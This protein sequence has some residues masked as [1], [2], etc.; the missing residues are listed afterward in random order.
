[1]TTLDPQVIK[2]F[3]SN[4]Q[5]QI[6][7]LCSVVHRVYNE[8]AC[9]RCAIRL[10]SIYHIR[11]FNVTEQGLVEFFHKYAS[12][13]QT[14]TYPRESKPCILC[15]GILQNAN[16]SD[17]LKFKSQLINAVQNCGYEYEDFQF[18][19]T[20]PNSSVIREAC[21]VKQL[22]DQYRTENLYQNLELI[23]SIKEVFK[24]MYA[25]FIPTR[26]K[27]E[28]DF[29]IALTFQHTE[30][31]PELQFF[32]SKRSGNNRRRDKKRD[33]DEN[34][35]ADPPTNN[36]LTVP[37]I[38]GQIRNQSLETLHQW[39]L[40]PVQAIN[41][42]AILNISFEYAY[43]YLAGRYNKF[44]RTLSQ[45]PWV[46]NGVRKTPYS[47]EELLGNPV[48]ELMQASGFMFSS[49]GREDVD[50]RMLGD[51]RPFMLEIHNPKHPNCTEDQIAEVER[52]INE[53][54]KLIQ[55]RDLQMIAKSDCNKIKLG[56]ENKRKTYRCVV[57]VSKEL[58]PA[59]FECLD[60]L[61]NN[62]FELAQETPIRVLHRRSLS[63]R[64]KWIYNL[65]YER[66]NSQFLLVDLETQAGTYVKEFIHGDFG[67]TNPNFGSILN[68]EAD[69]LQ[70]DVQSIVF[71][72]PPRLNRNK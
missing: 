5:N 38:L 6:H 3:E 4:S 22:A 47:V 20:I 12:P 52:K 15:F 44:S 16:S 1:M 63:T 17:E 14:I 54:T 46:I 32:H 57:H 9:V 72:W 8:G 39:K 21:L 2:L 26:F 59:D 65:T 67:R 53:S 30:T 66:I 41:Q 61:K 56:E 55:V 28:S 37:S 48:V 19:V 70:L 36:E 31:D 7:S 23:P 34:S 49:S 51:G 25:G 24:W 42:E 33:D 18:T 10:L 64:M 40:L 29:A 58:F 45:T 11:L 71:D 62:P 27:M 50:V 35:K 13:E 43:V 69:I 68:C 60:K